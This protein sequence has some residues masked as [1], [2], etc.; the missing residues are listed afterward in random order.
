MAMV[1][2]RVNLRVKVSKILIDTNSIKRVPAGTLFLYHQPL[3]VVFP[4]IHY[5]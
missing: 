1:R 4:R 3:G 2:V 5:I